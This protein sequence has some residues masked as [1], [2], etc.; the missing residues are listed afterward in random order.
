M[1]DVV[2][3]VFVYVLLL[4]LKIKN[5]KNKKKARMNVSLI[6]HW[7]FLIHFQQLMTCNLY[8][9]LK[10]DGMSLLPWYCL[11][12]QLHSESYSNKNQ[13]TVSFFFY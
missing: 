6:N 11:H 13:R 4:Y 3:F 1:V 8:S 10:F 7:T 5:K 12:G 2:Y 9:G